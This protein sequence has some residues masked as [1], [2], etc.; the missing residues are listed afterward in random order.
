M[1]FFTLTYIHKSL[2]AAFIDRIFRMDIDVAASAGVKQTPRGYI[3]AAVT[4]E[5]L[6]TPELFEEGER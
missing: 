1:P 5:D 6:V 3:L 2:R 4:Q